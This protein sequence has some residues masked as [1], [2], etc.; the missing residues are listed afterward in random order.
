MYRYLIH[1]SVVLLL[2]LSNLVM[3]CQKIV[4]EYTKEG[5]SQEQMNYLIAEYGYNKQLPECYKLQTLLAL[6]HFPELKNV[7]IVFKF[8]PKLSPLSTRFTAAGIFYKGEK[9]KYIV[10]IS[11][12]T[13]KSLQPILLDSLPFNAQVGVIGHELSHISD[14][15]QKNIFQLLGVFFGHL[16]KR[17]VDRFEFNTD[18][19]CIEHGLG[20]QL[21]SWSV[22]VREALHIKQWGGA[23]NTKD[24]KVKEHKRERYM[25]PETIIKYIASL[26]AYNL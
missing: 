13:I 9:K 16:S 18:K 20:Y 23:N 11:S 26:P 17:Y 1:M 3:F 8:K 19:I 12:M 2:I 15:S 21:L 25:N 10:T 4:R 14:L 6:S 24:D 5:V 7:H 22:N